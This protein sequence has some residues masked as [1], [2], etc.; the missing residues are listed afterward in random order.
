MRRDPS[1]FLREWRKNQEEGFL[2]I[3]ILIAGLILTASIAATMYLFRMG[4]GYIEKSNQSNVISSKLIQTAGLVK[5]LELDKKTGMEEM[6]DG[7]TL[8]WKAKLLG[9][10][11]PIKGELEFA[12]PSIHELLLYRVNFI[13]N[14]R[15]IAKE[16]QINV[17]KH[18]TLYSPEESLF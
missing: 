18:K 7:V 9:Q 16:Y 6:G 1:I 11:R 4:Y 2:V 13:L 15:G 17:F 12:A 8:S 3:E 10:T 5:T 14:Y